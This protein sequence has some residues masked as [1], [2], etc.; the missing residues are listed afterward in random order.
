MVT[1]SNTDKGEKKKKKKG[2]LSTMQ[3]EEGKQGFPEEGE[4]VCL[5]CLKGKEVK[6][7]M[8]K[9]KM[10]W[11]FFISYL[12]TVICQALGEE[13]GGDG[14]LKSVACWNSASELCGESCGL[15]LP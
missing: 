14:L 5:C 10:D 9:R 15:L 1:V 8:K 13:E 4:G 7:E 3:P 12:I 11:S 6:R 2:F